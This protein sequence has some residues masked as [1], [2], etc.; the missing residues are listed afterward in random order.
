MHISKK[1]YKSLDFLIDK[2]TTLYTRVY[3]YYTF[4]GKNSV[5]GSQ[6]TSS[7][8]NETSRSIGNRKDITNRMFGNVFGIVCKTMPVRD[9]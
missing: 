5:G 4:I 8:Q 9:Y 1:I 3:R 7:S 6:N 2:V